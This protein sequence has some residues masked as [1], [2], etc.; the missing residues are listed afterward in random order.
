MSKSRKPAPQE[1]DQEEKP[2]RRK[3]KSS[4]ETIWMYAAG[5]FL[6]FIVIAVALIAPEK[7][8]KQTAP[9][10]VEKDHVT[11]TTQYK[12]P[13]GTVHDEPPPAKEKPKKAEKKKPAKKSAAKKAPKEEETEEDAAEEETVTETKRNENPMNQS[14]P[15]RPA[16]FGLFSDS[17]GQ[18]IAPPKATEKKPGAEEG[19][20][21]EKD[22]EDGETETEGEAAR[23]K[24]HVSP[25]K[26]GAMGDGQDNE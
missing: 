1:Q 8:K 3:A 17:E 13:D 23:R 12:W 7:M 5:V 25:L 15:D 22:E 4:D 21:D 9:L 14:D 6:V 24:N 10:R 11:V 19:K 20:A 18:E 16:R 26:P 2:R